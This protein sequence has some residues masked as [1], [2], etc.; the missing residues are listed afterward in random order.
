MT[1]DMRT[2]QIE[3]TDG[4]APVRVVIP[5]TYKVTFG[6][7]VPGRPGAA[8]SGPLGV[9]IWEGTEKQ[10]AVYAN[11]A[12][13]RDLSIEELVPAARRF[14]TEEWYAADSQVMASTQV[15]H[16]WKHA[17]ELTYG[18]PPW[19]NEVVDHPEDAPSMRA[20]RSAW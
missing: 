3:F 17:D 15:E 6:A 19:R 8:T 20:R 14:G 9:R 5:A 2:Y 1:D 11:V 7:I 13:F 10:R 4:S 16:G 12:S 18:P